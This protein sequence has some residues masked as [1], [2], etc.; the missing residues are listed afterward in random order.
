MRACVQSSVRV[1][2]F[3]AVCADSVTVSGSGAV[4]SAR[5]GTYLKVAGLAQGFRPVYQRVGEIVAY[6]YYW[7]STS[8]WLVGVNYTSNMVGL[9][10]ASTAACPDQATGWQVWNGSAWV[11]GLP[12]KVVQGARIFLC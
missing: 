10:S 4:Q 11:S 3:G 2:L 9:Q 1:S 6:L 7:Q 12:V 5:M 8:K